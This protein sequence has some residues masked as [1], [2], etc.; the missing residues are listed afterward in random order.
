MRALKSTICSMEGSFVGDMQLRGGKIIPFGILWAGLWTDL[1]RGPVL[2]LQDVQDL[3]VLC[4]A[5]HKWCIN[6]PVLVSRKTQLPF[7]KNYHICLNPNDLKNEELLLVKTVSDPWK[8]G[9]SH[10][11]SG[12]LTCAIKLLSGFCLYSH[13]LATPVHSSLTSLVRTCISLPFMAP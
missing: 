12:G 11:F 2:A 13:I 4:A 1:C 3:H 5:T 6:K 9:P 7:W 10:N 8:H